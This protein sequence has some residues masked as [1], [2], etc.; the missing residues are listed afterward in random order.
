MVVSIWGENILGYL[1]VDII[2]ALKFTV[3]L[4]LRSW[5]TVCFLE[6]IMSTD[7]YPSIFLCQMET[8][9]YI[10]VTGFVHS[11]YGQCPKGQQ[12]SKIHVTQ[13][14]CKIYYSDQ[15]L[16]F[17]GSWMRS[18]LYIILEEFFGRHYYQSPLQKQI[19]ERMKTFAQ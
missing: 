15:S 12:V 1:S 2:C 18:L 3:F 6:Q 14:C 5:K 7:K 11:V 9:V 17:I 16:L 10:A 8:I 4:E 13:I 19:T